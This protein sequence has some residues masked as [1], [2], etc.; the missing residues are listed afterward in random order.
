MSL[1]WIRPSSGKAN[2]RNEGALSSY[3]ICIYS[4]AENL[5]L[6]YLV[7]IQP[8][9]TDDHSILTTCR[10]LYL[11]M[12]RKESNMLYWDTVMAGFVSFFTVNFIIKPMC[13]NM[14]TNI[15]VHHYRHVLGHL[16]SFYKVFTMYKIC[17]INIISYATWISLS[18][19]LSI[20]FQ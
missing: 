8:P 4:L 14:I 9:P 15:I 18:M 6:M 7:M 5:F 16:N 17:S 19:H 12:G 20:I 10:L 2:D 3:Y 11:L 13:F 1:T